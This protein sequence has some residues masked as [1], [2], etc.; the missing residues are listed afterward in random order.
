MPRD[1]LWPVD[2]R[3]PE[4]VQMGPNGVSPGSTDE[5]SVDGL[6][7]RS[8]TS[9]TASFLMADLNHMLRAAQAG[10]ASAAKDL[11]AILYD[12]L[13]ELARREMS[14]ERRDH[15]LQPTAL[16]NEADVRLVGSKDASFVDRESFFA[17][18]ATAIRRVLVDH[19][20]RRAREKRGAG[21]LRV[22]I[23]GLELDAVRA[24]KN[25]EPFADGELLALDEALAAL[26]QMD[27]T[28]AR[29]V[30]LRFFGGLT[31][32]ELVNAIGV[33]ESTIRREWRL[34]RA[35]LRVRMGG[36][37]EGDASDES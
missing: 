8:P 2:L 13:R 10:D 22:P 11:A 12:E 4:Y 32:E 18:A 15:T 26:A 31:V 7:G 25:A 19:A 20:R 9:S 37:K 27:P 34:A 24:G 1:F 16:V 36:A 33:S 30:E 17:A 35:W 5:C 21:R 28:K 29:L 23:D 6:M 14:K 3:S